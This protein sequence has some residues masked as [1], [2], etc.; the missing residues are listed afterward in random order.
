MKRAPYPTRRNESG[1]T[2]WRS[3][4]ELA[5]SP[6]LE[7]SKDR[8]FPESAK[9]APKGMERRRFLTVMGASMA[10][11]GLVGCRRPEE[12]I[13]P[14]ARAPEEVIPGR[15]LFFATT[16]PFMGTAFG[17]IV[18]SHE[19]RPTKIEGNP[20]HPESMGATTTFLQAV[21]LDMYDND[22]SDSPTE[23]AGRF[24]KQSWEEAA[25]ML[26]KLGGEVFAENLSEGGARVVLDLPLSSLEI[27]RA[28]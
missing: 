24:Q 13:L 12:K 9:E 11:S 16:M 7:E 25:S 28:N 3:L 17:L 19:G 18:E 21:V 26:R 20:R 8:E 6:E 23:G 27:S 2:Y 15:P 1:K 10:L 4:D 5:G 22:R 14:Y